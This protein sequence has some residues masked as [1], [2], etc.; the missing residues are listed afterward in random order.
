M[1]TEAPS[2]S[3]TRL[4]RNR[5]WLA[6]GVAVAAAIV[7]GFWVMNSGPGN[8]VARPEKVT[9]D[10][11][12]AFRPSETQWASLKLASV[13]QVSF[14][15]ERATDGKI[16]INEDTTTP[17][18]SPYSGRVTR[19]IAKPGDVVE[20]GAP[21]FAI[22][23]SEYVQGQN[24]LV[25]AV[26]SVDK[27]KSRL[28][29]AQTSEKR[30]RELLAI[31]GGALKDLE[32]AQSDLIGAQ[33][34]LRS[35]EIAL[36]ASR[37]RLRILGRSDEEI[38]KLET[39][40]RIGAETIVAAPING[41]VIQR[42]IG[43]GQ[44]ITVGATDPIFTVGDLSTVWLIANVRES[45]A[46]KMKVGAAV[47]VAVLAYPGRV[48]NARLAYVA[49]ALDPNTRRLPVRAEI[50]NPDH[51]LLPEMF[52]S[53]RIVSGESRLMPSVPQEAVVYEGAQARVW[54]ARPEQK[55]VVTRP[56]EVGATTNGLVE[57]R[58]GLSVGETV[59]ASGTLFIDRA[60]TR[61]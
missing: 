40:D 23:A 58:K 53:F 9:R 15:D 3:S 18:F 41:T 30:Q 46:P 55:A 54:V 14:R 39:V 61:D 35:A 4:R 5:L 52:A 43:V 10:A 27:A 6:G 48:F 38:G 57:V 50:R 31:R 36:A 16:A 34:D 37:N 25:T 17:V 29:L 47:E 49:P 8:A 59:V 2:T 33:G 19:L 51:E 22:D 26:A 7:A 42:R 60:A 13:S 28:A 1:M 20:R 24:D 56:I 12:G 11:D 45:D 21:L 32:Q 44:Y